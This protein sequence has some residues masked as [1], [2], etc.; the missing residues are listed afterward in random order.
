MKFYTKNTILFCKTIL[1]EKKYFYSISPLI[2][3]RL[4]SNWDVKI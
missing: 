2:E 3:K 1:D 4:S